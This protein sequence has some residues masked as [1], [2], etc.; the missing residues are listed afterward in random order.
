MTTET[1]LFLEQNNEIVFPDWLTT[2]SCDNYITL[3]AMTPYVTFLALTLP[4]ATH[5]RSMNLLKCVKNSH[6]LVMWRKSLLK[7]KTL[8]ACKI[9]VKWLGHKYLFD[10]SHIA[11]NSQQI[12]GAWKGRFEFERLTFLFGFVGSFWK[13]EKSFPKTNCHLF[14][15]PNRHKDVVKTS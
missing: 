7:T 3:R 8:F 10:F 12:L 5:L 11:D 2:I 13:I 9:L 14:L 6:F 4:K 15:K 1:Y